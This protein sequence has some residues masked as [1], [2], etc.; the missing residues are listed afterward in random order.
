[1]GS[2]EGAAFGRP[3]VKSAKGRLFVRRGEKEQASILYI[4]TLRNEFGLEKC[5]LASTARGVARDV[6]GHL[7]PFIFLPD[8]FDNGCVALTTESRHSHFN[9]SKKCF[10]VVAGDASG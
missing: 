6:N 10:S 3:F 4:R 2:Q 7:R 8:E 5:C 9:D 1:L